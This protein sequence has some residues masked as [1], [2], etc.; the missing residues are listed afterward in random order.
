[1]GC[2]LPLD[3]QR[4]VYTLPRDPLWLLDVQV[5]LSTRLITRDVL[6]LALSLGLVSL[7][8]LDP[9]APLAE[10]S[11]CLSCSGGTNDR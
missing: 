9:G 7:H 6:D 2:P 3:A 1:M 11:N 4:W 5:G 8:A 10:W